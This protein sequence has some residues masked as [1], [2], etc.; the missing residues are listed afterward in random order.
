MKKILIFVILIGVFFLTGCEKKEESKP[1]E[2]LTVATSL[3]AVFKENIKKTKD[4][5]EVANIITESEIIVPETQVFTIGKDDYLVGFDEEIKGF[6]KAVGIAPMISTI[7][8]IAYIFEVEKPEEFKTKLEEH[9]QLNW[10]ICTIADE[11]KIIIEDNY[12]FFIMSPASFE[13]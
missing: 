1:E 11:M 7:P 5:E 8:M 13:E 3:S 10:N 9:A 4:I 6:K 12:V 2:K